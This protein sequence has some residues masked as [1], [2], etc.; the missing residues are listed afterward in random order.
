MMAIM[1]FF[2]FEPLN[3]QDG[4]Y[5]T[6]STSTIGMCD[7]FRL[8]ENLFRVKKLNRIW[9]WYYRNTCAILVRVG[10]ISLSFALRSWEYEP[11][12]DQTRLIAEAYQKGTIRYMN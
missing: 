12:L 11:W 8:D 1:I 9:M 7:T 4:E 5:K 10:N 3:N 6:T 2:I